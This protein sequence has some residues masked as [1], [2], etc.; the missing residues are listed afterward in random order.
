MRGFFV[1]MSRGR[2]RDHHR[3]RLAAARWP[4]VGAGLRHHL[5]S[6]GRGV[7]TPLPVSG[8]GGKRLAV[9]TAHP[10]TCHPGLPPATRE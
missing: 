7:A 1:P 5:F 10:A 6:L 2:G 8:V 3:V 4:K 9:G